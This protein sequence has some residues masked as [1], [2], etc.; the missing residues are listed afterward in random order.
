[1]NLDI[2]IYGT[3]GGYATQGIVDRGDKGRGDDATGRGERSVGKA[4]G[5]TGNVDFDRFHT[6]HVS[7]LHSKICLDN[8]CI[9]NIIET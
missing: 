7:T 4:F 9:G 2:A 6:L 5:R 3:D 1:L 8:D